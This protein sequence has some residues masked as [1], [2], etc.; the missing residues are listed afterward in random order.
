MAKPDKDKKE[1]NTFKPTTFI[2]KPT[3]PPET[4][5]S[6]KA[7][8]I[9]GGERKDVTP[10]RGEKADVGKTPGSPFQRKKM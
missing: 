9:P 3:P 10:P 4:T 8:K 6:P 2:D 1:S 7:N 5:H